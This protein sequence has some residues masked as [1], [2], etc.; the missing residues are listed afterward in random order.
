MERKRQSYGSKESASPTEPE[1]DATQGG[2][3]QPIEIDRDGDL[4]T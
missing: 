4:N 2:E 3:N 1:K